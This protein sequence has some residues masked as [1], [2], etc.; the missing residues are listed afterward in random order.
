MSYK[1]VAVCLLIVLMS[2]CAG[3][4]PSKD[5]QI[6]VTDRQLQLR[7][8]NR[9]RVSGGLGIW[10][11]SESIS[12]KLDWQQQVKDFSLLLKAPLGLASLRLSKV[13]GEASLQRGNAEPLRGGSASA[14]LQRSLRLA[15]PVPVEQFSDWIRG[16]PGDAENAQYDDNG[17]LE[18]LDYQDAAGTRW[19]ATVRRYAKLDLLELPGLISVIGGPYHVRIVLKRWKKSGLTNEI[20][21]PASNRRP[22]KRL[23]IPGR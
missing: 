20:T 16:L 3:V 8:F 6:S 2:G 22:V 4:Q 13:K 19:Q 17:R 15:V 14:L 1:A 10:T 7:A 11:D 23:V 21:A 12:T 5:A 18:S 9:F